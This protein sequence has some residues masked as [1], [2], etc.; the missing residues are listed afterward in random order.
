MEGV[1]G[2]DGSERVLWTALSQS[3]RIGEGANAIRRVTESCLREKSMN[4]GT[5][6]VLLL[7]E[8]ESGL[9][10]LRQQL[11]NRGCRCWFARSSKEGLALFGRHCFQL[12]LSTTSPHE[13]NSLLSELGD[14][15][16]TVY[17]C[18]PVEDGC[19]WLP[20]ARHGQNCFGAPGLRPSEFVAGLDEMLREITSMNGLNA[21]E[22]EEVQ[23]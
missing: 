1:P 5:V 20:M 12:I 22:S 9:S 19:W 15:A 6:S 11:E 13:T 23:T 4:H 16:C 3:K 7:G 8:R 18:Y 2:Q 14:S 17:S 10:Y 21:R